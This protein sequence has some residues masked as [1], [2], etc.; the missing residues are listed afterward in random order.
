MNK[1][2]LLL[3]PVLLAGCGGTR[4]IDTTDQRAVAGMAHVMEL[5]HRDWTDTADMMVKSMLDSGAFRRIENPVIAMG[6]MINDTKQRFDTDILVRKI[7]SDLVNSGRAQMATNFTGED[8]T[9]DAMRAQRGNVEFDAAT[10]A[11][12]GTLVAPNMS[13]SG[14]MI[15]R[16]LHVPGTTFTRS[17]ERVE[18]Y[19]QLVLTDLRTGLS[20]WEEERQIVKQGRN[21]P[22]W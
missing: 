22:R 9:S 21:A 3:I 15:Q 19:L 20:V 5:E 7:R 6:P 1:S 13:L 16:N 2:F 17:Q 4:V 12:R 18:Y 8:T 10:I 14:K 11:A